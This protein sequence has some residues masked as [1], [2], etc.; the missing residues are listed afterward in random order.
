MPVQCTFSDDLLAFTAVRTEPP[1]IQ[2]WGGTATFEAAMW[3]GRQIEV[4]VIFVFELDLVHFGITAVFISV[5]RDAN[6][7]S[8]RCVPRKK[9]TRWRYVALRACTGTM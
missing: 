3:L 5:G 4:K 7:G 9:L 2:D 1:P 8:G 6:A